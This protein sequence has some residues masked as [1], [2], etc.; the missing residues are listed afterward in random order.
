MKTWLYEFNWLF[1][2]LLL[3]FTFDMPNIADTLLLVDL[4]KILMCCFMIWVIKYWICMF[5][6]RGWCSDLTSRLSN[7][8]LWV[9]FLLDTWDE[10]GVCVKIYKKYSICMFQYIFLGVAINRIWLA[11]PTDLTRFN[12]DKKKNNQPETIYKRV[13]NSFDS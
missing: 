3:Y 4:K 10:E 6:Q 11:K 13:G 12:W 1:L 8:R 5:I 2:A 7:E 9:W